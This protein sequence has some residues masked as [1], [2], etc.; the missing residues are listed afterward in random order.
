[1][2]EELEEMKERDVLTVRPEHNSL[3]N[4][5]DSI[6]MIIIINNSNNHC[7]NSST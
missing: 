6:L 7:Y 5:H 3:M 1:M 4:M 2:K